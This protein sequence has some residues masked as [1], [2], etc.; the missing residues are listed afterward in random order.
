MEP[1]LKRYSVERIAL[2][3]RHTEFGTVVIGEHRVH[4]PKL[5]RTAP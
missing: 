4:R 2:S 3:T 5:S 1:R